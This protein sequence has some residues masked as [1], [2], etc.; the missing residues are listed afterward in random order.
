MRFTT[1]KDNLLEGINIVQK[2]VST[3]SSLAV[4]EGILVECGDKLKLTGNDL[5]I[6]IE[7]FVE[8]DIIQKGAVVIDSRM[9]GEIVRRL[10][11]SEVFIES[12]DNDIVT[13]EC[14]N[15]HFE[16]HGLNAEGFPALPVINEESSFTI[17]QKTLRDMIRQTIFA[18]SVD[19]NRPILTGTLIEIEDN[20]IT[21][22]S[23]DSYRVALRRMPLES[24]NL[25][26]NKVVPGKTLNE[27]V[28]ILQPVDD[29]VTIFSTR[30]QILFDT[31]KYK[32]VSRLLEGEYLKYRSFI[33]D[34]FETRIVVNTKQLL[35]AIERASLVIMSNERRYPL[36]IDIHDDVMKLH[37]S[38]NIG[39]AN[40]ELRIE[41]EGKDI[42]IHFNPRYFIEALR[43]IDDEVVEVCFTNDV[44]PCIIKPVEGDAFIY[45]IVP[46]RK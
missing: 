43:V 28:K 10:P 24:G 39:N 11:D 21:F 18:V 16:I 42:E 37:T 26:I 29:N 14:E 13:I 45:L 8:A 25:S 40:E 38:T 3:K 31:G 46:L 22:V 27:L 30:N 20:N 4:L 6:G 2:A 33:P 23:C 7:C 12:N 32:L 36:N 9:F 17:S 5:E 44:G 34:N 35:S 41:M 1:S 19:D 15:S